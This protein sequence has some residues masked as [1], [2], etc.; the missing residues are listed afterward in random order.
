MFLGALAFVAVAG[1]WYGMVALDTKGQWIRA[2]LENENIKRFS[3]PS[4][5]HRGGPW[6]H[7]LGLIVLFA[8]WS[9][10]LLETVWYTIGRIR[11]RPESAQARSASSR[12][13][14]SR[15]RT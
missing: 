12:R 4:E 15:A 7:V 8:P 6:Y 14:A 1:P 5:G 10:F 9:V 3:S 13:T 11:P 2:F